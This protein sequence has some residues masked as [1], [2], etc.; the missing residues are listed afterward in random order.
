MTITINKFKRLIKNLTQ[1]LNI[2]LL[3]L[4]IS[5]I[6]SFCWGVI[7]QQHICKS[8]PSEEN[9]WLFS[10]RDLNTEF[11]DWDNTKFNVLAPGTYHNTLSMYIK[12][13]SKYYCAK[14]IE[15]L[16]NYFKQFKLYNLLRTNYILQIFY[17]YGLK[18]YSLITRLL[19]F[20]F[21]YIKTMCISKY[22]FNSLYV[23]GIR[24]RFLNEGPYGLYLLRWKREEPVAYMSYTFILDVY[25][26]YWTFITERNFIFYLLILHIIRGL[27][28]IL[29]ANWTGSKKRID[30]I[31]LYPYITF[32]KNF[33]D[34]F[35]EDHGVFIVWS[36]P[37]NLLWDSKLFTTYVVTRKLTAKEKYVLNFTYR[38]GGMFTAVMLLI[39][40]VKI[41]FPTVLLYFLLKFLYRPTF[42]YKK[43][44][45]QPWF[46]WRL[47]ITLILY[48]I[49]V[50]SVPYSY[51]YLIYYIFWFIRC[52]YILYLDPSPMSFINN[53]H[54][55]FHSFYY[56]IILD[57][58]IYYENGQFFGN[59]KK[60]FIK[61]IIQTSVSQKTLKA[62]YTNS[63]LF[64]TYLRHD[65]VNN[66]L[67]MYTDKNKH[68]LMQLKDQKIIR[69]T[70]SIKFK[71]KDFVS[72][73][74]FN[75]QLKDQYINEYII[76]NQFDLNKFTDLTFNNSALNINLDE[77]LN[78][79]A[80]SNTFAELL[81]AVTL[82]NITNLPYD[83]FH[84]ESIITA[85]LSIFLQNNNLKT[86]LELKYYLNSKSLIIDNEDLIVNL[87]NS[88][89]LP[90]AV[91]GFDFF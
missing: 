61:P 43:L 86:N 75:N 79:L 77:L 29:Y 73:F 66:T 53:F 30:I 18:I 59:S 2:T 51:S 91:N 27:I 89:L 82:H 34:Y 67:K 21:I 3:K 41:L 50:Y 84:L 8:K 39:T 81:T 14:L 46:S 71:P 35:I 26:Y 7:T 9:D 22:I 11:D 83:N 24:I 16:F 76:N 58:V 38:F 37:I 5:K 57:A 32:V 70:H 25:L 40:L 69:C 49:L 87:E 23:E 31:Y 78:L 72:N 36:E 42:W 28:I 62:I 63:K 6:Y 74:D 88:Q 4:Y 48:F 64:K 13:V 90:D 20:I 1:R 12:T 19:K 65:I 45:K 54:D 68:L 44:V 15:F 80:N 56:D 60:D 55:L 85:Q 33:T 52:W 47:G 17:K 10:D